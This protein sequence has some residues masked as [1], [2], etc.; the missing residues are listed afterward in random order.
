MTDELN[1]HALL[2]RVMKSVQENLP[3]NCQIKGGYVDGHMFTALGEGIR[4]VTLTS[5]G[6]KSESEDP[7]LFDTP[8]KAVDAFGSV[9]RNFTLQANHI[10]FRSYPELVQESYGFWVRCQ[11]IVTRI[12]NN[13]EPLLYSPEEYAALKGKESAMYE[14]PESQKKECGGNCTSCGTASSGTAAVSA[15]AKH[16]AGW[17]TYKGPV[18]DNKS[19]FRALGH[20]VLLL[21]DAVEETTAGGIVLV[22][23]TVEA[24]RNR[25]V[26]CTVVEIGVDCWM[27]KGADFCEVGDKVLIGEYVGKFH[28]SPVDDKEYRFVNDL[29]IISTLPKD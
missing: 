13:F 18:D 6:I 8:E 17:R 14:S 3:E 28:R 26:V 16:Q 10:Y 27:D 1:V 9:M 7:K 20:R 21:Q 2:T 15:P 11:L 24:E 22:N 4:F 29:E 23:K 19:G 5:G 25:T 12:I